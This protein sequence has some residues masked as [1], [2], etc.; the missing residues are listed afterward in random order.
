MFLMITASWTTTPANDTSTHQLSRANTSVSPHGENISYMVITMQALQGI[1]RDGRG[2]AR[3]SDTPEYV[4]RCATTS[5]SS[6]I[7][8]QNTLLLPFQMARFLGVMTPLS[9]AIMLAGT[10]KGINHV[11]RHSSLFCFTREDPTPNAFFDSK[12]LKQLGK[13]NYSVLSLW[14]PT[15]NHLSSLQFNAILILS[16]FSLK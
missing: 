10:T 14:A 9:L 16:P 7:I 8:T 15:P 4:H 2:I 5:N 3:H 13:A 1:S 11:L 12:R 6:Q